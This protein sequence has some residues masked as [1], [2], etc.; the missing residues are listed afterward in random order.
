MEERRKE[1]GLRGLSEGRRGKE[2]SWETEEGVKKKM[3]K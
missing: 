3:R 2:G 1:G